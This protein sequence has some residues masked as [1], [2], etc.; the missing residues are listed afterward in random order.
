M[1]TAQTAV[2]TGDG[3]MFA[4]VD[5]GASS[6]RVVL[7]RIGRGEVELRETARFRNGP[8][9]L[10]DGLRWNILGL[11]DNILSGLGQ[12]HRMA[13]ADGGLVSAAIDSWAVDYGLLS[14]RRGRTTMLGVPFHYR[15]D[16]TARGV[17]AVEARVPFAELYVRNGLQFLP[18]NTIYQLAADELR[19][20]A[21]QALLIPDL[22]GYWLTGE[23]ITEATN[24]S[25]TGLLSVATG[26]WDEELMG[27]LGIPADLFPEVRPAGTR[28]G[29]T[30]KELSDTFGGSRLTLTSVGSHDTAS[31][32]V[33]A[34]LESA[35]SAY[36]SCGTWGLVGLELGAPVLSDAARQANFTN[37]GGVDGR[38]RFLTNV[39]GTWL[40]SETLRA[41]EQESG[42]TPDLS[43]LLQ[44]AIRV[45]EHRIVEFDVQDARFIPP[46]HM[47]DRI[48]QWC[49][50]RD[51]RPPE[52]RAAVVRSI[53]ESIAAG[54]AESVRQAA[55]LAGRR[56]EVIH[57]V[58]G[59]S[60]NEL[61]CR[62]TAERSGL[63]V[64]AGPVEATALGNLLIQARTAGHLDGDLG[65]LRDLIRRTHQPTVYRPQS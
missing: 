60:Q 64:M 8:V 10:P 5:L 17:A 26:D 48:T 15:D 4:A 59:G 52:G 33:G 43:E 2:R 28:I 47:P 20:A 46:G 27:Q 23:A 61:L 57:M 14:R 32:V 22:L 16:R 40:L 11:Y 9:R 62:S 21:D 41:W 35:Q 39:M 50:E 19:E 12:A 7:G 56:V 34:P 53:V 63:P 51:I 6:G 54:F 37:E 18:F 42:V 1:T 65:D 45:P 38:T 30:R 3:G 25:T 44:A 55:Q 13:R 29:H 49:R 58:G 24:A 31:A 36:I